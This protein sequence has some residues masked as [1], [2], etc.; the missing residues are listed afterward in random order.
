MTGRFRSDHPPWDGL[1]GVLSIVVA[2]V[3]VLVLPIWRFPSTSVSGAGL[4]AFATD[5]HSTLPAVMVLD[6]AAVALWMVFGAGL[7]LRL[8]EAAGTDTLASTSFA[9][10]LVGF[11]TLLLAGF[12]ALFV[13]WYVAPSET[14]AKELYDLC[15]GLLAMSGAPTAICMFSYAAVTWRHRVLPRYTTWL[16]VI[17][18]YAH[19]ALLFS[20]VVRNGWFSLEGPLIT[21]VPGLLFAWIFATSVAMLSTRRRLPAVRGLAAS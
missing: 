2:I 1:I 12:V 20:M 8:R 14:A 18:G 9:F 7:W 17:T 16:A 3:G 10:G 5:H 19:V 15:F 11:T 4:I 13:I 6:L 21:L